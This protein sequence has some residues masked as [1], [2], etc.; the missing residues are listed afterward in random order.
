MQLLTDT[1]EFRTRLQPLLLV[2]MPMALATMVFFDDFSILQLLSGVLAYLGFTSFLSQV[3][4][5][6][7]KQRE[8]SL[9]ENWGGKPTTQLLRHRSSSI[10]KHQK[11]RY[12]Q[13]LEHLVVGTKLPSP[14][15][16]AH[17]PDEA[18]E[19]YEVCISFL[20]ERTRDKTQ[21]PLI[22]QENINYGF[23]RNLWGMKPAGIAFSL[24]GLV[25]S[26][27]G[28]IWFSDASVS[29]VSVAAVLV[30]GLMVAFWLIRITPEWVKTP[31][32]A[33]A[34]RL[35][36]SC[37]TLAETVPKPSSKILVP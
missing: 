17:A 18:D 21:F 31:A 22:A 1:Y 13:A 33:Y 25:I 28:A 37:D 30:N 19:V 11:N 6:Q 35:L 15:E 24:I 27:I 5:D 12:H 10:S 4:R 16:E 8:Q 32:F 14:Q 36:A 29:T 2:A 3:A 7:G 26:I 34:E 23:R 9:F 20:R